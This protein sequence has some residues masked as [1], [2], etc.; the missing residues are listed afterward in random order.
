MIINILNLITMN[1]PK[2]ILTIT[3]ASLLFMGCKEKSKE[4]VSETSIETSTPKEK[5][6]IAATNIQRASFTI[7]GMTCA[8]GCAKTI[9]EELNGLDGVE[10][11]KVDFEKKSATISYDKSILNPGI[12]TKVVQATGDGKTYKVSNMKS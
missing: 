1:Y 10:I 8:I 2:S 11:A 9:Q 12:I 4:T 6:E 7:E 5:K 3:F